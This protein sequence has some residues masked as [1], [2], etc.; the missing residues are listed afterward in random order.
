MVGNKFIF[1]RCAPMW[2]AITKLEIMEESFAL[3]T[4]Q[5][6]INVRLKDA[7]MMPR[8]MG[9]SVEGMVQRKSTGSHA[10]QRGATIMPKGEVCVISMQEI[11]VHVRYVL[12]KDVEILHSRKECV[13]D[14]EL[15]V[16]DVYTM[17]VM[18][19]HDQ[20]GFVLNTERK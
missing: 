15:Y 9:E 16:N 20:R 12:M 10:L 6:S 18:P 19:S 7:L 11:L 3:D 13:G 4:G 17:V 14:T 8:V 1:L 5:R 2:V